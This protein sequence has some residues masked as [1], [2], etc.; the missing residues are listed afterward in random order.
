MQTYRPLLTSDLVHVRRADMQ[1]LD[2]YLHANPSLSPHKGL[3]MVFNPTAETVAGEL[4][5]VPLYYTGL[6]GDTVTVT[7]EGEQTTTRQI[8]LSRSYKIDVEISKRIKV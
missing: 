7:F 2:C 3:A 4:L 5:E 1:S 6:S 8:P